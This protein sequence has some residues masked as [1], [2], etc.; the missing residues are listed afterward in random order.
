MRK[1]FAGALIFMAA[2]AAW[3]QSGTGTVKLVVPYP[4]G[5]TVDALA[6]AIAPGLSEGL[7]QSVIVENRAG[8]NEIIAASYV[9]KAK[10][11]GRTLL[12]ATDAGLTM[13]PFL[14]KTLPYDPQR[15]FAPV[16]Q[17]VTVPVVLVATKTLAVTNAR[18]L[19]AL[20]RKHPNT[21]VYAT[22]GRGGI[23]HV[24]MATF[25]RNNDV[26]LVHAPYQGAQALMPDLLGGN[27][28]LSLLSIALVEQH[29]KAGSLKPLAVAAQRRMAAIPDVPTFT[30][31]GLQ[32]IGASFFIGIA[33]PAGTPIGL[34]E[35]LSTSLRKVLTDANFRGK[36]LDPYAYEVVASTPKAF[37]AFLSDQRR[38][39]ASRIKLSG[40]SLD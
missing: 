2:I 8:A 36:Y 14:Y 18:E 16:S 3:P 30:E 21:L 20:A 28:H 32:D 33:A 17:L 9:A 29:I 31:Q 23:T 25:E 40:A 37:D 10:P 13:N 34:R 1:L 15:D 7:K 26:S 22:S 11:D 35:R 5:G 4:P 12:V 38:M 24:P 39:Q 6:R 27:V 19:V